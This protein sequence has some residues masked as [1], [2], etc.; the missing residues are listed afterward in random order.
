MTPSGQQRVD[1]QYRLVQPTGLMSATTMPKTWFFDLPVHRERPELWTELL[2]RIV[3]D[4]NVRLRR[5]AP[6]DEAWLRLDGFTVEPVDLAHMLAWDGTRTREAIAEHLPW[7]ISAGSIVWETAGCLIVD[8]AGRYDGMEGEDFA[9][10]ILYR[11]L[12][13][14]RIDEAGVRDFL[15]RL[16]PGRGA[17]YLA[18]RRR[19]SAN[20]VAIRPT[21]AFRK[22]PGLPPFGSGPPRPEDL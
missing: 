20:L 19:R 15:E 6:Y 8:D 13:E 18:D 5:Q 16:Y 12:D 1:L 21:S 7:I 4:A 10:L 3:Y 9:E 22:A 14:G 2:H 17:A 11:A